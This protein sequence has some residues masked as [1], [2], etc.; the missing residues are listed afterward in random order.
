GQSVQGAAPTPPGGARVAP[1]GAR[2]SVPITYMSGSLRMAAYYSRPGGSGPFP[3]VIFNHGSRAGAERK[4]VNF[5]YMAELFTAAGYATLVPERRGYGRSDGPTFSE[6]VASD[7][8]DRF[9][10]R[11][12]QEA[13]DVIA[14]LSY[15][16]ML[17]AADRKG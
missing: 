15:L 1:D 16:S 12:Q 9:V 5:A 4:E 17:P 8:G 10:A 11:L 7:V 6:A 13:D 3:M 14:S 2:Q